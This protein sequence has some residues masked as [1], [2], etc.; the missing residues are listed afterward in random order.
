MFRFVNRETPIGCERVIFNG[1][2][3]LT[4]ILKTAGQA[5]KT[6]NSSRKIII[7]EQHGDIILNYE[8]KN[9]FLH[10]SFAYKK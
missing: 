4:D 5:K 3:Y 6:I 1:F 8:N 2:L 9:I 7:I 10:F